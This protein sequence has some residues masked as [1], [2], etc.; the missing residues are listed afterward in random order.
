MTKIISL[1]TMVYVIC[2]SILHP[3]GNDKVYANV[4]YPESLQWASKSSRSYLFC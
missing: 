1:Y 4:C 2:P 3:A